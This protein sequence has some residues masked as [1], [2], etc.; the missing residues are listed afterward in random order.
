M[1][2]RPNWEPLNRG[3]K[4]L[5]IERCFKGRLSMWDHYLPYLQQQQSVNVTSS[6]WGERMKVGVSSRV[7]LGYQKHMSKYRMVGVHPEWL[8]CIMC[9]T[10]GRTHNG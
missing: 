5:P 9:N 1:W 8:N 6:K 10:K 2:G 7:Q 3:G 4:W